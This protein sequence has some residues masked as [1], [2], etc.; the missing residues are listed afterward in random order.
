MSSRI[1]AG[2]RWGLLVRVKNE[3]GK[4]N[5]SIVAAGVAFFGFL[6]IFPALA[7]MVSIYGLIADPGRMEQQLA[8]VQTIL[9]HQAYQV[10]NQQLQTLTAQGGSTLGW[11]V[12]VGVVLALWSASSGMK[13]LINAL[14]IA[15]DEEEGRGFVKLNIV[16]LLLTLAAVAFLPV[17][18]GLIAALPALLGRLGLPGGLEIIVSW[19]RWPLLLLLVVGGLDLLYRYAPDRDQPHWRW[20]SVGSTAAAVLWLTGSGLFSF[21][22]SNF[23]KYNQT[24]G[25]LAA[26]VILLLWF[27]LTAFAVLVGAELDAEVEHQTREPC[28]V[29]P[30]L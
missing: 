14:N 17:A 7:A 16:A 4:D 5:L 3:I 11:G 18:L 28:A 19:G 1:P 13:A 24:Y 23:G 8:I 27:Y 30:N 21:Y 15:Y 25:S 26:I 12:L 22:V 6:A 10:L 2:R 29:N 20:V 9:P